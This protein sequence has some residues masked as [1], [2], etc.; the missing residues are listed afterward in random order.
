MKRINFGGETHELK[1]IGENAQA[2]ECCELLSGPRCHMHPEFVAD[3]C[4]GCKLLLAEADCD[5][6]QDLINELRAGLQEIYT[7]R[8]EDKFI[9][10]I[11]SPLIDKA[12]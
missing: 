12:R 4:I 1:P 10:G 3:D 2:S 11:A 7:M 8:G 5:G 9:A 6:K